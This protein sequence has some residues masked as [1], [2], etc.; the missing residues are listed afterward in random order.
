[1]TA[2]RSVRD[3]DGPDLAPDWLRLPR[4]LASLP[5]WQPIPGFPV[6]YPSDPA[7]EANPNDAATAA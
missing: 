7:Y 4:Q 3:D 2:H 5:V 6:I 1:M